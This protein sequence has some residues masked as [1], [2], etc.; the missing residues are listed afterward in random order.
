MP[1]VPTTTTTA[2]IR[3][4]RVREVSTA[5]PPGWATANSHSQSRSAMRHS[6]RMTGNVLDD[7]EARGLVQDH[8]DREALAAALGAGPVVVYA[9]FDPTAD[10]LHLGNLVPL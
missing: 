6:W 5:T 8:T 7:L 10:S 9:G 4:N 2:K 3:P 1:T